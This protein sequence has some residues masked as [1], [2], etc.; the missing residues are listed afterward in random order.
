MHRN[1]KDLLMSAIGPMVAILL[2]M[3]LVPFRTYTSASNFTYLFLILTILIAEYG[4]RGA[5]FATALCSAVS[6]DFFLTQP[7]M[8]LMIKSS[9]DIAAFAGLA[10]C[11]FLVATFGVQRGEKALDLTSARGQLDLLHSAV[12]G[13]AAATEVEFHLRELLDAASSC[14]PLAAA[15]IKD[16]SNH[17]LAAL[18]EGADPTAVPTQIL[19]PHTLLPKGS[20]EGYLQNLPFPKEG[21]RIPL[22]VENR[23]VGWLDLWGNEAPV[24]TGVRRT[25]SDIAFLLGRMLAIRSQAAKRSLQPA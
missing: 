2:G 20:D 19:S 16:E 23:Q 12:S 6:L 25:L 14:A 15:A 1:T 13:L 24:N 22:L 17:I 5:A 21:A 10:L 8:H 7:Y 18:A 3:A 9:H 4:G 11:G